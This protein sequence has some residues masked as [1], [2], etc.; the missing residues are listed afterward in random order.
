MAKG[1][2]NLPVPYDYYR[3]FY[4]VAQHKSFTKAAEALDNN[5][6]N[7]TRCMNNLEQ[8]LGCKLFV[9][10][11]HGVSLTPEGQRLYGRTAVA[12]EQ[13]RLGESEIRDHCSLETGSI[14]IAASE[15]ALHLI[16]LDRLAAF[17][18]R[19]PGVRLRIT[20]DYST[21]RAVEALLRGQVDC[22]VVTTPCPAKK[23][24]RETPLVPFPEILICGPAFAYLAARTRRLRDVEPCPFVCM[25]SGTSTFSFYQR[26]F[27]KHDLTFHVD[28]E[29]AT[30]D[31]VLPMVQ[32]DLGIGFFPEPMAAAALADGSVTRIRLTESVPQRA[33]SLV[34]DLSRPQSV[35]MKALKK[36]LLAPADRPE[37]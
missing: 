37:P 12:F 25:G 1:A 8:D 27:L 5:Q 20:N 30:M 29:A 17:H 35:A 28:M 15:T 23:S 14:S 16:L 33:V 19:Y 7:I 32:H 10:T 21:P 6:P 11:N 13:L 26:L 3:I 31:Q 9:R 24:L 4:Y 34:E 22:A 18:K 36:L 2:K